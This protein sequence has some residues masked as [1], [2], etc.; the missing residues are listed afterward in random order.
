ME[1]ASGMESGIEVFGVTKS[2]ESKVLDGVTFSLREGTTGVLVG[3]S[4]AGKTTLL[5]IIS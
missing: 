3:P 1:A 4:G 2:F 5:N